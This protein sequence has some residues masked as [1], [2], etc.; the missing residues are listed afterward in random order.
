MAEDDD[1]DADGPSEPKPAAAAQPGAVP[2]AAP[3][4]VAAVAAAAPA[5]AA[6]APDSEDLNLPVLVQCED[7]EVILHFSELFS[8]RDDEL[9]RWGYPGM[10]HPCAHAGD[11][12]SRAMHPAHRD[13]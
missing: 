10:H 6:A 3:A 7:G 13:L 11:I 1:Y 8:H 2:A 4:A 9:E 5:A 12:S